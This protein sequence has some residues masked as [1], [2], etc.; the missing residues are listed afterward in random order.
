MPENLLL[1]ITLTHAPPPLL[2][3]FMG[4]GGG[5]NKASISHQ[6]KPNSGSV[7]AHVE[8]RDNRLSDRDSII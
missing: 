2:L 6:A 8:G 5:G 4:G 7:L 3:F 1:I